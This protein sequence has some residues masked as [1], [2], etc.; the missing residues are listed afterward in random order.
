MLIVFVTG[1]PL[2]YFTVNEIDNEFTTLVYN[3]EE[4]PLW[5]QHRSCCLLGY[6]PVFG[7]LRIVS[8][9]DPGYPIIQINYRELK[10]M[11]QSH[12]NGLCYYNI[13][14]N[15]ILFLKH[16]FYN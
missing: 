2:E 5:L 1:Q 15:L 13:F 4:D 10:K 14:L 12:F 6:F 7:V 3:L 11:R 9:V 16:Y 8:S